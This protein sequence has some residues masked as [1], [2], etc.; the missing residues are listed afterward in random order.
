MD[1]GP[2]AVALASVLTF[3]TSRDRRKRREMQERVN[4]LE[5][6]VANCDKE[7]E[8]SQS[9]RRMYEGELSR[10]DRELNSAWNEIRQLQERV[11]EQTD[12]I[13]KIERELEEERN[14]GE[15]DR[16]GRGGRR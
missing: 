7:R 16:R 14:R 2:F 3:L 1:W 12:A 13:R 6:R 15:E 10:R 8:Q 9:D 11:I 4:H 5:E